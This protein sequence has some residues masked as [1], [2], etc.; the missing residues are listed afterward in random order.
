M[1]SAPYFFGI[2]VDFETFP[3]TMRVKSSIIKLRS[4]IFFELFL[5]FFV[6]KKTNISCLF[7]DDEEGEEEEGEDEAEGEEGE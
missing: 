2:C 4:H 5:Y 3:I 6:L 1:L 7:L